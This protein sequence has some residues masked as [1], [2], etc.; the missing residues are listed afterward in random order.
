MSASTTASNTS[1]ARGCGRQCRSRAGRA[2][3]SPAAATLR[4][5]HR[6]QCSR[7]QATSGN[8]LPAPSSVAL[9]SGLMT[10][11]G[12]KNLPSRGPVGPVCGWPLVVVPCVGMAPDGV[13]LF[14][15]SGD[16]RRHFRLDYLTRV[17]LTDLLVENRRA[18]QLA[19]GTAAAERAIQRRTLELLVV[20]TGLATATRG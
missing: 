7:V 1:R 19:T 8:F 6:S 9:A 14:S 20:A 10:A 13:A 2:G 3:P 4:C 17:P 11:Q 15:G 12:H 18:H 16:R 5:T